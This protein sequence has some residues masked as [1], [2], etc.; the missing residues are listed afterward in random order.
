MCHPA[1]AAKRASLPSGVYIYLVDHRTSKLKRGVQ[2]EG[3]CVFLGEFLNAFSRTIAQVKSSCKRDSKR[4]ETTE[5]WP[6][7]V[8][9]FVHG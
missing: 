7:E 8:Q 5:T 4:N 3:E 9:Y 2:L 1:R 6:R